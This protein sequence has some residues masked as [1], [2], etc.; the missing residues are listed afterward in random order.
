MTYSADKFDYIIKYRSETNEEQEIMLLLEL[1]PQL[2]Q[3]Q[4]AERLMMNIN[5]VK[6]YIRKMQKQ[7]KIEHVGST[8]KGKWVV[9]ETL[10]NAG[11]VAEEGT[12]AHAKKR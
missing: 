7:G 12:Y 1:F 8:R 3:K 6:Y 4:I 2:S 9:K 11:K 10:Y 5:T